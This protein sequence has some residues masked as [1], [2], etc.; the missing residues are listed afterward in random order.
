M[1]LLLCMGFLE[2]HIGQRLLFSCD[3]RASQRSGVSHCGARAL[4]CVGF[5]SCSA[6]AQLPHGTWDLPRPGIELMSPE[7]AG[8]FLTTGPL[9]KSH[10]ETERS[11]QQT[12]VYPPSRSYHSRFYQG[13]H[14]SFT[15]HLSILLFFHESILFSFRWCISKEQQKSA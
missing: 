2:L 5:S 12:P 10:S 7:L 11:L 4:G 8:G 15:T 1:S 3:S 6:W 14:T 9:G 13:Y